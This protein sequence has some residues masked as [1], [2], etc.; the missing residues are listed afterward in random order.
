MYFLCYQA[1]YSRLLKGTELQD[2]VEV[3]G[4]HYA[5]SDD[6]MCEA[7]RIIKEWAS[8]PDTFSRALQAHCDE[9]CGKQSKRPHATKRASTGGD[10]RSCRRPRGE[11]RTYCGE[12][13]CKTPSCPNIRKKRSEVER[14][15]LCNTC[16][17][18]PGEKRKRQQTAGTSKKRSNKRRRR[19]TDACGTGG[20]SRGNGGGNDDD[21]NDNAPRPVP[22]LP[23]AVS[24]R[25]RGRA[26]WAVAA[27]GSA[28]RASG[29][30]GS[31][32]TI[33]AHCVANSVRSGR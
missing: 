17:P 23:T 30:V 14:W 9:R 20:A 2:P 32:H 7:R 26:G 1:T 18:K 11:H 3:M 6:S 8:N 31:T 29:E 13:E 16:D 5:G 15:D 22:S 4:H 12:C 27:L 24:L 19:P 28:R 21:K 33:A 25:T 10:C